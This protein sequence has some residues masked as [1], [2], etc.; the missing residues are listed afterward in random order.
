MEIRNGRFAMSDTKK[1]ALARRWYRFTMRRL[2]LLISVSAVFAFALSMLWNRA[3]QQRQIVQSIVDLGGTIQ[4]DYH[5]MKADKPNV[6]DP[7]STPPGPAWLRAL[8]GE[9]HFQDVIMVNLSNK[10]I[11]DDDLK[12]L[13]EL[14][15]LENLDLSNTPISNAG[16]E[17]LRKIPNL[18]FLSLWNTNIDDDGLKHLAVHKNLF[19]LILDGTEVT[20]V[21]LSYLQE[22]TELDEWFGLCDTH[23]TDQGIQC[24]TRLTKLKQ[25]NVRRTNVTSAGV[26]MLKRSLPSTMISH[27]P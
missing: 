8:A 24:L 10:D 18:K 16:L 2:L 13:A 6:F 11:T 3:V 14:P 21:G 20:D 12:E 23:V 17:H 1:K 4:Y 26:D 25:L 27:G 19:A 15:R 5:K 7:T 9:E 22:L